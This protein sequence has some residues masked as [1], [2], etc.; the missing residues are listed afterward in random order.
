MR[1]VAWV[2]LSLLQQIYKDGLRNWTRNDYAWGDKRSATINFY[3]WPIPTVTKNSETV[4]RQKEFISTTTKASYHNNPSF[5]IYIQN[6]KKGK[7]LR[8]LNEAE[9][10]VLYERNTSFR[11]LNKV[12]DEETGIVNIL[13]EELWQKKKSEEK[14]C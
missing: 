14:D 13:L 6:A 5:R 11:V 9:G 10:E 1:G 12:K 7:D 3:K 4:W 8:A 2:Y